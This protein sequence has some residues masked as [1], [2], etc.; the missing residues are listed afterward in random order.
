MPIYEYKCK[1]CGH[2][3]SR[4]ESMSAP[5]TTVCEKCEEK[6]A[7]RVFSVFAVSTKSS[8]ADFPEC[9]QQETCSNAGTCRM[10]NN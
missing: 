3:F 10:S 4:L 6:T 5:K 1:S 7:H 9:P 8:S 2:G